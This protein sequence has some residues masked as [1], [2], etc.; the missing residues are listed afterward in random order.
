LL[1]RVLIH[2]PEPRRHLVRYY[3]AYSSVVRAR[4]RA[5]G[6]PCAQPAAHEAPPTN[7]ERRALRR[8]W[9]A[10]IRRIFEVDPLVCPHCG[11]A[12]RVI[13]FITEPKVVDKILRHLQTR[14][15][16]GRD[17]PPRAGAEAA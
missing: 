4:R 3:G 11:E 10:L 13:A 14:A 6:R 5:Q 9:A 16:A 1:A 12:M 8:T 7:P 15:T 17:P 2:L